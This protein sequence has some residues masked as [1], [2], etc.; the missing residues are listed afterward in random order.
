MKKSTWA[1]NSDDVRELLE[2]IRAREPAGGDSYCLGY[3]AGMMAEAMTRNPSTRKYVKNHT[4]F[5]RGRFGGI[6]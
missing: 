4:D 6:K 3:L 5:M 1:V 2:V